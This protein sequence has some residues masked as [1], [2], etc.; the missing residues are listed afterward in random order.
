VQLRTL[1]TSQTPFG[2]SANI[3]QAVFTLTVS[4]TG[5]PSGPLTA[6]AL[7]RI[8][9][10]DNQ[11]G[12]PGAILPTPLM[13]RV[14]DASG[15]PLPN[16]P[17][18]W[19]PSASVSLSNASSASDASGIVSATVILGSAGPAQVQLRTISTSQTPFGPS[20]NIVQTVFNLTASGTPTTPTPPSSP[21]LLRILGGN[22]QSGSPGGLLSAPLVARVED[23]AGNPIP[24]APVVWQ[25]SSTI[26]LSNMSSISDGNGVVSASVILGSVTGPAQAQVRMAN[27]PAIQ[28]VFSLT[29]TGSTV[30]PTQPASSASSLRILGGNSQSGAPGSRLQAPLTAVIEDSSGRPVPNVPVFW[31]TSQGL[32]LSGATSTSDAHGIVSTLVTLGPSTGPA[33]VTLRTTGG[34]QTPFGVT[35]GATLQVVFSLLA[36]GQPQ[37]GAPAALRVVGG[38]NQSGL[39]GARLPFTLAA[40]VE[41]AAGNPVPNVPVIWQ[42]SPGAALSLTNLVSISDASGIVSATAQLGATPGPTQA[43]VRIANTPALAFF[44][45]VVIPPQPSVLRILAGNNLSAEPGKLISLTARVEDGAGNPV[46]NV[47]VI[48]QA[49]DPQI[50]QLGNVVSVS[51]VNGVVSATATLLAPGTTQVQVRITAIPVLAQFNLQGTQAPVPNTLTF[52]NAA[53]GEP[54]S[55]SPTGLVRVFGDGIATGVQGCLTGSQGFGPLPLSVNGVRVQFAAEGY[56]ALAPIFSLCNLGPGKE[57]IVIQ[58]PADL[59]LQETTVTVQAQEVAVAQSHVTAAAAGPGIFETE[60]SDGSKRAVLQRVDGS[61]VSLENPAQ[62][63][64]RLRAFVTGLGRAVTASGTQV[65]TNQPGTPDDDAAP[66]NPVALVIGNRTVEPVSSVYSAESLGV[67]VVTFDLPE[68]APSGSDVDLSVVTASGEQSIA[69][70]VSKAPIQ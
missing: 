4:A 28:A 14:E 5:T 51:D 67:Y 68:D 48:W 57:Y 45:L 13:A 50:V 22:N 40:R 62:K 29:I 49:L 24:N 38:D 25:P 26:S 66:P 55:V 16:T 58:A 15:I 12:A 64:E 35:P 42:P 61:Y 32:T 39:P 69:G 52:L 56:S 10:G 59:P 31:E 36:V 17:V 70:K 54:G 43:Q 46:P 44:N 33:Q 7:L 18:V 2:P 41:D 65:N 1:S 34:F 60:M 27:A 63:G 19:Q 21:A 6:P 20:A 23:S 53:S 47:S 3:I 37:P 11:S 9:G 8:L 30:T